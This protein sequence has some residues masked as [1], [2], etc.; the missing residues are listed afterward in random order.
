[1]RFFVAD[2]RAGTKRGS[3]VAMAVALAMGATLT[4]GIVAEPA[5]A[6]KKD[7][8]ATKGQYSKEYIAAFKPL[9]D[10][11]NANPVDVAALTALIPGIVALSVSP[12]EKLATGNAVYSVG[13]KANDYATQFKGMALMIESGKLAPEQVGQFNFAAFQLASALKRY[14]ESRTYLQAAMDANYSSETVTS[15]AMRIAMAESF[16]SEDR[17]DDGLKYILNAIGMQKASGQPVDEEW[18]KRGLSVA[19][20]NERPIVYDFATAWVSDYPSRAN[21]RDS[22]NIARNLNTFEPGEMLDLMRL[23]FTLGAM[24]NKQEY[25]DYIEAADARR[26]PKEVETVISQGYSSGKVSKDDIFVADTLKLAS[27][28]IAA[29]RADLPS[30]EKDARAATAGLRT[31]TA[32]GD[33][34]LSY[35]DYGKA[36]EFYQKALGMAGVDQAMVLTR[37]GVAQTKLGKMNEAQA[38]LAKV[39]T[40][41]RA[42]IAKLWSAYAK[43][44]APAAPSAPAQ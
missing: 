23:S 35:A 1:M 7:K 2:R 10:G 30:L 26:L 6:A 14:P 16:I 32:A 11:L 19:Y 8:Q 27:G 40:G 9:Q 12:D 24:D 29:D 44:K 17:I 42:A 13:V 38:T 5:F 43:S 3:R 28:R 36:E 18:Y 34:F 41:R 15:S 25:I 4:S 20:N 31:V 22:I 21:W 39:T 33:T 37:L